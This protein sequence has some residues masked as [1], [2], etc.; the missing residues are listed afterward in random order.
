[1]EKALARAIEVENEHLNSM[2]D[3]EC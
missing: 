3:V 2:E 1:V